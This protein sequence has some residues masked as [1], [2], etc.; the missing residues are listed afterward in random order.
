MRI[1]FIAP[2]YFMLF[3]LAVNFSVSATGKPPCIITGPT[4][5]C[6]NQ[7]ANY[8]VDVNNPAYTY[9]WSVVNN[10]GALLSQTANTCA[11]QWNVTGAQTLQVSVSQ[12]GIV[13]YNCS[14]VV[15]V[16][17]TPSPTIIPSFEATC[18]EEE[19][20]GGEQVSSRGEKGEDPC[21]KVC[22]HSTVVYRVSYHAGSTYT[23]VITG[24]STTGISGA[25]TNI[26]TV[27]WGT[28][29]NGTIQVTETNAAG[30]SRTVYKC[31]QIIKAP[32]ANF[33]TTPPH[34][35]SSV[36]ICKNQAVTFTDQSTANSNSP[37]VSW[38]W[39]FGDGTGTA[40]YTAA[41]SVTHQYTSDNGGNPYEASLTV[42]NA[43]GCE[44]IF[45]IKIVVSRFDVPKLVCPSTVCCNKSTKYTIEHAGD[46]DPG[47]GYTWV[48]DGG[49]LVS[50]APGQVSDQ[51]T[52]IWNCDASPKT[53]TL[54]PVNCNRC[55]NPI[56]Y[57][58]AVITSVAVIN[59]KQIVCANSEEVYSIPAMPGCTFTW[60]L[61][62][63]SAGDIFAGAETNSIKVRWHASL[64]T[65]VT[66]QV[67]YVNSVFGCEGTGQ[68]SITLRPELRINPSTGSVCAGNPITFTATDEF[69]TSVSVLWQIKQLPSGN[70][71]FT[72]GPSNTATYTFA[73]GGDYEITATDNAG[74][75]CNSP[76]KLIVTITGV[77]PQHTGNINGQ[78]SG[79]CPGQSYMYTTTPTSSDYNL[80]WFI[81]PP[82]A[83]T[84]T[85][86]SGNKVNI[87][88]NS[89]GQIQLYQV[90][91]TNPACTSIVRTINVGIMSPP[92]CGISGVFN[93]CPNS[94]FTYSA[95]AGFSNYTWSINPSSAGSIISGQGTSSIQVQ[96]HNTISIASAT[97]NVVIQYCGANTVS[98]TSSP[99]SIQ[100]APAF[101]I[102]PSNGSVCQLINTQP[103][104]IVGLTGAASVSWNWGDGTPNTVTAGI[105][106]VTHPY[107]T[108]GTYTITVVVQE[109]NN[110]YGATSTASTTVTVGSSPT[111]AISL[112]GSAKTQLCPQDESTTEPA[113]LVATIISGGCGANG[114]IQWYKN[115]V[116][117]GQ[118]G[119]AYTPVWP[120]TAGGVD[121]YYF[122]YICPGVPCGIVQ[123]NTL[124]II[125]AVECQTCALAVIPNPT[126]NWVQSPASGCGS[127]TFNYTAPSPG[128]AYKL[129]FDDQTL[130]YT[131]PPGNPNSGSVAHT[132]T[133]AGIY[134]AVLF[135]KYPSTVPGQYCDF[136]KVKQVVVPVIAKASIS[137]VCNP[138]GG[139]DIVV[140]DISDRLATYNQTPVRQVQ[141]DNG[142]FVNMGASLSYTFTGI[143]AG[144]HTITFKIEVSNGSDSYQCQ[145][146]WPAILP[147]LSTPSITVNPAGPRCIGAPVGFST[148]AINVAGY[149]WQFGDATSSLLPGP[150]HQYNSAF[151]PV[152]V[153]LQV[154]TN[155]GCVVSNSITLNIAPNNLAVS[156]TS[157]SGTSPVT[158]CQGNTAP[159]LNANVTGATGTISYVWN[160]SSVNNISTNSSIVANNQA[161][162]KYSVTVTDAIGCIKT[163]SP[164]DVIVK[165]APVAAIIGKDE[166]CYGEQIILYAQQGAG[167]TYLWTVNNVNVGTGASIFIS[168]PVI[169]NNTVKLTVTSNGCS[170]FTIINVMVHSNPSVWVDPYFGQQTCAG[171]PNVLTAYPSGGTAPYSYYWNT[172]PVQTS[173]AITA[174]NAGLYQVNVIDVNGCKASGSTRVYRV[175]D[176]TNFMS[177]CYEFC[178]DKKILLVG[179]KS[180]SLAGGGLPPDNVPYTM[181]Y[182]YQWYKDGV[183]IP[184]PEGTN[185]DYWVDPASGP[186]SGSG[187]YTL[188]ITVTQPWAGCENNSLTHYE[189]SF[190]VNF[191]KCATCKVDMQ[192]LNIFCVNPERDP[193]RYAIVLKV[194]NPYPGPA[195]L[196][197]NTSGGT[198]SIIPAV[199]NLPLSG[200]NTIT[201]YFDNTSGNTDRVCITGG[202]VTEVETDKTCKFEIDLCRELPRCEGAGECRTRPTCECV[203][204][205]YRATLKC[206]TVRPIP[207]YHY[208]Y[209]FSVD[210]WW[211]CRSEA[212]PVI[213]SSCGVF[214]PITPNVIVDGFNSLSGVFYTNQPPGTLCS[215]TV[216]ILNTETGAEI[217]RFCVQLRLDCKD[218][219]T[220]ENIYARGSASIPNVGNVSSATISADKTTTRLQ[221]SKNAG[222]VI[223]L[224]VMTKELSIIPNPASNFANV[225]YTFSSE[226]NNS[227][228]IYN[229]L[230]SPVQTFSGLPKTGVLRIDISKLPGG[231]YFVKGLGREKI[232]VV[233]LEVVR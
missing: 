200:W 92:S 229:M 113:I 170:S 212:T 148:N 216:I 19:D 192:I 211:T 131:M 122:K 44:S 132:Y 42:K 7:S 176:F 202:T 93:A 153:S 214:G 106:P 103:Y 181:V 220:E 23:W 141:L 144:N 9:Q 34:D 101:T 86:S 150:T 6:T 90:S 187:Q 204:R 27:D 138:S 139:Y 215:F 145:N 208:A 10:A 104:N 133:K 134:N 118:T 175:E 171:Q 79:I 39:D 160:N 46:E 142:A 89:A 196:T 161:S 60:S 189:K 63:P 96:W 70:I 221:T 24:L 66:L 72:S 193:M 159:L 12:N 147:V 40:T 157:P 65:T 83:G 17:N 18:F 190:N 81:S 4:L 38:V 217:C 78:T 230:G 88:W 48:V 115:G 165:P 95:A 82:T 114:N 84:V 41:A 54:V 222:Q 30:C 98:C 109:P 57:N 158:I 22:E 124:L 8:Q 205:D 25:N 2:L 52:I 68:L 111:V 94:T 37:I 3:L 119:N 116:F 203:S 172:T 156:I 195:T 45:R 140:S 152:T 58:I 135:T 47:C 185:A 151:S 149:L 129:D 184:A 5:V 71:V 33:T 143:T 120:S 213:I 121:A 29:S 15:N 163:A 1:K 117:T 59:G 178:D 136:A 28:V 130:P 188:S 53:I 231:T 87:V 225:N 198:I 35:G 20:P 64:G 201:V 182:T 77:P 167:Y 191:V 31:I 85:P 127:G 166:Y 36:T 180:P 123:S 108:P 14:L 110:C 154:T 74:T 112:G 55:D 168:N 218:G 100:P 62:D 227:V 197:L 210:F 137:V 219:F 223:N 75:T 226:G 125:R 126:L 73:T 169:G 61:S 107:N 49:T 97:L 228:V 43:C 194:Y 162:D 183:P 233:K 232:M 209:N 80:L 76:V 177:G 174:Y 164:F 16:F 56:V 11:I 186:Y 128:Y 199:A 99:I 91:R 179:P 50:P 32:T 102:S 26:C 51:A 173:Q 206:T 67:H 21:S 207:G 105:V 69:G 224:P 155:E 146:T 13:L